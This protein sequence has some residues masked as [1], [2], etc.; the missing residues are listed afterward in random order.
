[1]FR[2]AKNKPMHICVAHGCKKKKNP[3]DRF[4]SRHS[5]MF[6]KI[7]NP[8]RYHYNLLK[9]NARKRSISFGVSLEEFKDFCEEHNYL[10]LKGKNKNSISIDRKDPR[11]G[12]YRKNMQPLTLAENS[13][14]MHEDRKKY[15][16]D[17]DDLP[18]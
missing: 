4:C 6:Q 18:F 5:K 14:K 16:D 8:L 15:A 7:N 17:Y 10:E 11:I 13:A 12:Y 2:I 3:K 9:S 1:M